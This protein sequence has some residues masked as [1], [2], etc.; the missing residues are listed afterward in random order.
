MKAEEVEQASFSSWCAESNAAS[1]KAIEQAAAAIEQL[2][3]EIAKAESDA[4]VLAEEIEEIEATIA[5]NKKEAENATAVR[6]EENAVYLAEHLDFSES[7][8][9]LT[10]AMQVLKA[11]DFDIPQ[12]SALLQ[13]QSLSK[14]P[15]HVKAVL[16][17]FLDLKS[18]GQEG[19]PEA[20]AYDFQ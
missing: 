18:S 10:R 11:R 1:K 19:A 5:A 7:I 9:A 16:T 13:V 12:K 6:N 17:S 2:T 14:I 15:A 3:A 20:N 8:D 4:A